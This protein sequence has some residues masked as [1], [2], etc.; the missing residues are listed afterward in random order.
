MRKVT[1]L[2]V[3]ND[4]RKIFGKQSATQMNSWGIKF[5]F[6]ILRRIPEA[7]IE[8]N[9]RMSSTRLPGKVKIGDTT[10]VLTSR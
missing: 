7:K 2:C 8:T 9:R 1:Q 4:Y 10:K 6:I 3:V 5:I